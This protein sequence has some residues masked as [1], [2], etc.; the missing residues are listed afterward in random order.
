LIKRGFRNQIN[1]FKGNYITAVPVIEVFNLDGND[2]G[3]VL[4]TDGLWD[5]LNSNGIL[6]IFEKDKSNGKNFLNNL[7]INSLNNAAF[8]HSMTID[9]LKNLKDGIKRNYHDDITLVYIDLKNQV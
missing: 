1:N 8:T 2:L 3:F 4:G 5:E 9:K 6:K 7:L